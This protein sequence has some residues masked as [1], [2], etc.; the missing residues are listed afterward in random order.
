MQGDLR[1][2]PDLVIEVLSPGTARR[3][4]KDKFSLYEKHG[5]REYWIIDPSEKLLEVWQL[6]DGRFSRLD[7][8]GPG[9]PFTSLLLGPI[10]VKALL[11]E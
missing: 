2:A 8:F 3:D 7:V 9:D 11:P 5:V 1:G 6:R 10:D 4:K